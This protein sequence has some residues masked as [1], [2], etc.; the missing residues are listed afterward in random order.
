MR[1]YKDSKQLS[2]ICHLYEMCPHNINKAQQKF[3]VLFS[4]LVLEIIFE[5]PYSVSF[6]GT[7]VKV[8][9]ELCLYIFVTSIYE[10]SLWYMVL[11]VFGNLGR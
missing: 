6:S 2:N 5:L 1:Y 11:V 9:L 8:C 7:Q 10:Q 3:C 4:K